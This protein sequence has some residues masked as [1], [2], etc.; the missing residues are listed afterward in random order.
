MQKL[1]LVAYATAIQSGQEGHW[2]QHGLVLE[3]EVADK[4]HT[5]LGLWPTKRYQALAKATQ[6]LTR[7]PVK[8]LFK[9]HKLESRGPE[10]LKC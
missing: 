4:L 7:S 5:S 1:L 6:K 3:L 10:R 2:L 9:E 8:F